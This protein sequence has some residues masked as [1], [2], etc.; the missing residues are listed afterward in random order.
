MLDD[1][2][3]ARMEANR[4][5][6][7]ERRASK[8]KEKIEQERAA[9]AQAGQSHQYFAQFAHPPSSSLQACVPLQ[10][11]GQGGNHGHGAVARM[12]QTRSHT[13]WQKAPLPWPPHVPQQ[14]QQL[15]QQSRAPAAGPPA[16]MH[17]HCRV[18]QQQVLAYDQP[19][20]WPHGRPTVQPPQLHSRLPVQPPPSVLLPPPRPP[21]PPAVLPPPL[22]QR[23]QRP[24]EAPVDRPRVDSPQHIELA[25]SLL[26]P[27]A[28][29]PPL[30]DPSLQPAAPPG[31]TAS[32]PSA[33]VLSS[34][35]L[36][37][38]QN[39]DGHAA[40][41]FHAAALKA[42]GSSCSPACLSESCKRSSSAAL[43]D[44]PSGDLPHSR[45]ALSSQKKSPGLEALPQSRQA[46]DEDCPI[47]AETLKCALDVPEGL[48]GLDCC[49][50]LFCYGCIERWVTD[51]TYHHMPA[52]RHLASP[53]LASPHLGLAAHADGSPTSPTRV[54]CASARP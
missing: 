13:P 41:P 52:V 45:Q 31:E 12:D 6:A 47:C 16:P 28:S 4:L 14:S 29:A 9:A 33:R 39:L 30:T 35:R 7:M 26:P 8:G 1:A 18:P 38:R 22:P 40:S 27:A 25:P 53:E 23:E 11:G 36:S 32:Q 3:R 17:M 42:F 54:R 5:A 15:G 20:A 24:W 19:H 50:H 44:L 2:Q 21:P 49:D 10:A 46:L 34:S 37:G 51:F 43:D 48:G